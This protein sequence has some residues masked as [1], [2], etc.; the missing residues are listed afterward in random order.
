MSNTS[1]LNLHF[2]ANNDSAN[3][4]ND[5]YLLA[6]ALDTIVTEY[7]QQAYTGTLPTA[8][9][10]TIWWCTTTN[11]QY[12]GLNYYD[13]TTWHLL[14]NQIQSLSTE[15]SSPYQYQIYYNT[16][17]GKLRYYN[18]TTWFTWFQLPPA[19]AANQIL[20]STGVAG[21]TAWQTA[22][23]IPAIQGSQGYQGN[24][25]SQGN[26][27]NQG[28][29]G[30]T[31]SQGNQG[32]QGSAGSQGYQ[33][34][35]GYQGLTGAQGSQGNQGT[36][37]YQSSVQGPQ[38]YQGVAGTVGTGTAGGDLTG[39]YPNP[40]LAAVGT[41]GTYTKVTTDTKGRVTSGTTLSASDIPAALTSA[42][43]VGTYTLPS[44]GSVLLSNT[45]GQT[46]ASPQQVSPG[47]T[48]AANQHNYYQI[49]ST[50]TV[51]TAATGSSVVGSVTSFQNNSAYAVALTPQGGQTVCYLST[52]VNSGSSITINPGQTIEMVYGGSGTWWVRD[53]GWSVATSGAQGAIQ[54]AGDLGGTSTSP[55]VTSVAH[56]ASGVLGYQNGGTG[57]QSAPQGTGAVVLNNSPTL[58]TPN[59]GTPSAVNLAN[60]T[61]VLGGFQPASVTSGSIV[62][63]S[64]GTVISQTVSGYN[65]YLVAFTLSGRNNDTVTRVLSTAIT[66]GTTSTPA[67]QSTT[68]AGGLITNS[69][70]YLFTSQGTGNITISGQ[71]SFG[72]VTQGTIV[73]A[74]LSII[75]FN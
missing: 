30:G 32:S 48:L 18:G 67:M 57:V 22:A 12:Y 5:V 23:S 16:S 68:F 37:G 10:G 21:E 65:N 49:S 39:S 59:L 75:G 50:G 53:L 38:G 62:T 60:A 64:I 8:V 2:P 34:N 1:R 58:V 69:N 11:C 40:T 4:P 61:N 72:G 14:N 44:N 56:I 7:I 13:G 9:A 36:Q 51:Y 54:L 20:T 41:Q 29:Q 24:Q 73:V 26:Q 63:G 17:N 27:G 6:S 45:T 31:G 47:G 55:T 28:S 3:I 15:P 71:A 19:G 74:T 52:S 66:N 25:G 35:Q 46:I 70:Q 33:G 42:T 43:Q